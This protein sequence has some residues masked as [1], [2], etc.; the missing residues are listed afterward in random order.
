MN[1]LDD[2]VVNYPGAIALGLVILLG[3]SKAGSGLLLWFGKRELAAI[4]EHHEQ[5]ECRILKLEAADGA[6]ALILKELGHISRQLEEV[7]GEVR[8]HNREA[9]GWKQTIVGHGVRLDNLE[10]KR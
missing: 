10:E 4:R 8:G 6:H 3:L 9:E 5:H 1:G 7:K 2:L